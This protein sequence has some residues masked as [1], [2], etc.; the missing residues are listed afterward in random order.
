M[1]ACQFSLI[2]KNSVKLMSSG[3]GSLGM[4]ALSWGG[5]ALLES[6]AATFPA[7][8]FKFF[9]LLINIWNLP[10]VAHTRSRDI[11]IGADPWGVQAL[12]VFFFFPQS[13]FMS[14]ISSPMLWRR[15]APIWWPAQTPVVND[16]RFT[17]KTTTTMAENTQG[18]GR[19]FQWGC[20]N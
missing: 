5:L 14:V 9:C 8:A 1:H 17:D 4:W 15:L 10:R 2:E 12:V 6:S 20:H 3:P 11:A 7:V 19:G 16:V 13:T 18:Q